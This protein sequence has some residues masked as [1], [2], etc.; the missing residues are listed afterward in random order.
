MPMMCILYWIQF[1]DKTTL[2]SSAIL[3]IREATHLTTN[4]YN[5]LGTIFYLSYLAFEYPQN[6]ALQRF[7]VG[8]WMSINI[9]IWGTV[10]CLHAACK[11]FGGLFAVRFI[12]GACEGAITAGFMIVSS[13]FYTRTE[14]TLRV[15]YWFLMNGTAQIISGF[16]S[17][18]TLHIKTEGFEPWQWLMIITG[19]LTLITAVAY[20]F[21]FPDS[22]TNAWFLTMD[23]RAKAVRRI[24]ENQTGVENKHFKK[25]QMIEA[26]TDPKTWLFA[27]FSA[28][29]NVPN[30]LTNQRTIIVSSFG[31]S[32][33]QTTLLGCVDGFIEIATIWTGVTLAARMKNARA[34]VGAV[35]FAP[36]LLGVILINTLPWSDKVGLLFGQWLTGV[37]TTGFV[38]SLSWLSSV[39]AG[40]TKK[41]TT[42]AIMLSAYCV[43]NAAGP[44]MWQQ[45][46]KP[47]NHVP[48]IIIGICY[49]ICPAL[50]LIIRRLLAAENKR[51][52]S[53]PPD[54]T[55][56][57]VYIETVDGKGNVVERKVDKEF[58]DLTDRQNRDFR[59]VL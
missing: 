31:F 50:L 40:H 1:M 11:N 53:E 19:I 33:L 22:P 30:S 34:W 47:R 55:Y 46:Y 8:K 51:R 5:W 44:F 15:G 9:L 35:Y 17:F 26:L 29:D 37:G 57:D 14:Q 41:V 43:G 4:E 21:L 12:L 42:N 45:R 54:E 36:N 25:E 28:L 38:L 24:K 59:Y 7:P 56:D 10:L 2:G 6:L 27:L 32:N 18:G 23:E 20:W 39:T 16:I 49:V 13:M 3:G 52:D 48:W 58:L